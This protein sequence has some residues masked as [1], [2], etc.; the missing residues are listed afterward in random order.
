MLLAIIFLSKII[1]EKSY[2]LLTEGE[3]RRLMEMFSPY[4]IY[5]TAAALI[6]IVLLFLLPRFKV[7][8]PGISIILYAV[9]SISYFVVISFLTYRKL[10]AG[11][12]SIEFIRLNLMAT[13]LRFAGIIVLLFFILRRLS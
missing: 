4:R 9:L 12:Y 13:A 11:N 7:L 1:N 10:N 5:G 8:A 3:K 2:K 6:L